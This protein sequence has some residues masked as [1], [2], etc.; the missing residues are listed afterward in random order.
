[1]IHCPRRRTSVHLYLDLGIELLYE[2][3]CGQSDDRNRSSVFFSRSREGARPPSKDGR[4]VVWKIYCWLGRLHRV[5]LASFSSVWQID[6]ALLRLNQFIMYVELRL[7]RS[8][9]FGG[10]LRP[11]IGDG[12]RLMHW[13]H[14]FLHILVT[15]ENACIETSAC[16][17][18]A[19][20]IRVIGKEYSCWC[21]C[22]ARALQ[23]IYVN[24]PWSLIWNSG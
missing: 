12:S 4:K 3:I 2:K 11:K 6:E 14:E 7:S 8:P 15:S 13:I 16:H 17:V 23:F 20:Q 21:N 1:M 18:F 24:I 5:F 19:S 9:L 10:L 22:Q